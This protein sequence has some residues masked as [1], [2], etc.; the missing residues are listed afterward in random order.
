MN[1][2]TSLSSPI[3][4][5]PLPQKKTKKEDLKKELFQFALIILFIFLPLRFFVAEPFIVSGASMETTFEDG[6]YLIVDILSLRFEDL[7]RGD[8]VIFRYPG[9]PKRYYIKRVIGLPGE[10]VRIDGTSVIITTADGASEKLSEPYLNTDR[11]RPDKVLTELRS[12]EF[13]V[14]GDNRFVSSDSRI[15]GP[16]KKSY[17]VGK[18]LVRLLPLSRIGLFPGRVNNE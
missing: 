8:V 18:P 16:L 1:E 14:M 11:T 6:E 13:F 17:I 2:D 3:S 4:Q 10:T 15:W 7:K 9:D 5:A 12:D